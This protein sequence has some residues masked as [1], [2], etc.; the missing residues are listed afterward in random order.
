M[1]EGLNRRD[2]LVHSAIAGAGIISAGWW[3]SCTR[4]AAALAAAMPSTLAGPLAAPAGQSTPTT[5][6]SRVG[7][8]TNEGLMDTDFKPNR[9]KTLTMLDQGMMLV[10]GTDSAEQAWRQVASPE[11]VVALKVN[12]ECRYLCTNPVV[13][14]A[15]AQRLM[16]VGVPP[17]N[18][19]IFDLTSR[20][21]GGAGYELV[22]SGTAK[23][24]CY[25]TDGDYSDPFTAGIFQGRLSNVLVKKATVL[26]NVPVLKNHSLCQ[27]TMALK[28][29]YGTIDNPVACHS[30]IDMNIPSVNATDPIKTKTRLVVLDASRGG[31]DGGPQ[32][33]PGGMWPFKGLVVATDPVALDFVGNRVIRDKRTAM[34]LGPMSGNPGDIATHL[35]NAAQMGL[36]KASEAEIDLV[37]EQLT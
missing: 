30:N 13:S 37:C 36:G 16:D 15:I 3:A 17:Q 19:I 25:G 11:D 14:Y 8:Y 23:P 21:L 4:P 5:G 12:C 31:F 35:L 6:K 20:Q 24:Y 26:I 7:L 33:Q 27:V 32:P 2:F 1:S 18:I 34:K 10:F 22:N 9:D 29:H 28:N